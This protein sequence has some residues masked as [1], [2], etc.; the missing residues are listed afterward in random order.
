MKLINCQ[1]F[2]TIRFKIRQHVKYLGINKYNGMEKKTV[3]SF[4][5][6]V[7]GDIQYTLLFFSVI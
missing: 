7:R 6:Q 5:K 3:I 1:N 2:L 4:G